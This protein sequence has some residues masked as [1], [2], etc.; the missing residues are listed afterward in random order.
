MRVDLNTRI[1]EAPDSSLSNGAQRTEASKPETN[2]TA[3][4]SLDN[5]TVQALA[6]QASGAPEIRHERVDALA[7]SIRGGS[8]R[9]DPEK[10][11]D[12][13]VAHM[14]QVRAA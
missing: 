13:L 10:T 9:I 11:A 1:P 14:L 12:A 8:Y 2:D 4:L 5:R 3:K 6:S 7:R